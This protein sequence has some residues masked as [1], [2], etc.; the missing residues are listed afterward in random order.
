MKTLFYK[1]RCAKDHCFQFRSF[2]LPTKCY[3]AAL[4][5]KENDD[6]IVL[7]ELVKYICADC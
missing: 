2:I 4:R 1:K 6:L 5:G 3:I 7:T